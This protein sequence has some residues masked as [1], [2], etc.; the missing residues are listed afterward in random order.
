MYTAWVRSY[1][2]EHGH[3]AAVTA[4]ATTRRCGGHPR[5]KRGQPA[6]PV[7]AR[8]RRGRPWGG[9]VA[10]HA[11]RVD[12]SGI[13]TRPAHPR[14]GGDIHRVGD[15]L[16]ESPRSGSRLAVDR[17]RSQCRWPVFRF[18]LRVTRRILD[19]G[20]YRLRD[21]PVRPSDPRAAQWSLDR[22]SGRFND[23][24]FGVRTDLGL[25]LGTRSA[26]PRLLRLH[27]VAV[28]A[29]RD[30]PGC[31]PRHTLA[32]GVTASKSGEDR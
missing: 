15:L 28:H 9:A 3:S 23:G 12:L 26:P 20:Y 11:R 7:V 21:N 22:P 4:C 29:I 25:V 1:S 10:T 8:A 19:D 6:R 14:G 31:D 2:A 27:R 16:S 32:G 30:H 13:R 5:R 24:V 17:R 18:G